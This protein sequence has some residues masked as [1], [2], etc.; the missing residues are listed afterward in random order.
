MI[1]FLNIVGDEAQIRTFQK[2]I[3]RR[4]MRMEEKQK[5]MYLEIHKGHYSGFK[6]GGGG[7]LSSNKSELF[8]ASQSTGNTQ[9]ACSVSNM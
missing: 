9:S 7:K 6:G 2:C 4:N 3:L 1:F 5:Y 8:V